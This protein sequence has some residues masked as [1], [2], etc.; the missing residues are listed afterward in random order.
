MLLMPDH[1]HAFIAFAH[2]QSMTKTIADWKQC[3]S[4]VLKIGWQ[5]NFFD[6]RLRNESERDEKWSYVLNNPVRAGLCQDPNEWP[7]KR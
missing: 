1:L 5:P 7:F 4:R 3:S 2:H 6:H